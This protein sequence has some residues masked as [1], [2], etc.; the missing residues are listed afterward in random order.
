[1]FN[2]FKPGR[3]HLRL[4]EISQFIS[5][6]DDVR[7][8]KTKQFIVKRSL[9]LLL[10]MMILAVLILPLIVIMIL[11]K[12]D[13]P[14]SVFFSQTRV[15]LRGKAFKLYKLRTMVANA[16]SIQSSLE[17]M[18]EIEDGVLF[19]IK[20][21][22]RITRIGKLL[23]RYSIDEIPQLLNVIKGDMSL[24]GPRPLTCR[25]ISKLPTNQQIRDRVLP[26]ITGLWQVSG[27]SETSSKFMGKCDRFY[28]TRWSFSLDL[29]ILMKT[30]SVVIL[31]KGAY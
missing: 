12:I 31:S 20:L 5:L 21:D 11:I 18:N 3:F 25:D 10:S 7:A 19:K 28:V 27:R 9:D 17:N 8:V 13:S 15:G 14:G 4:K 2:F 23:R 30:V 1:M 26:G 29:F 16:S 22:P 6:Q 24:V